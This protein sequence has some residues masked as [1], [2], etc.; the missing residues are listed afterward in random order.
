MSPPDLAD[1]SDHAIVAAARDGRN[2]AYRELLRRYQGPIHTLIY[3]VV[4]DREAAEEL[5]QDTF[6]KLLEG[7]PDY[8]G[9]GEFS[10]WIFKIAN[11]RALS[12]VRRTK[13][14]VFSIDDLADVPAPGRS[15]KTPGNSGRTPTTDDRRAIRRAVERA[16]TR[17][18]GLKRRCFTMHDLKGRSYDDI[19]EALGLDPG[20]VRRY[21][22]RAREQLKRTLGSAPE[23]PEA[24]RA[25]DPGVKRRVPKRRS[26]TG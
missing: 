16:A 7:L 19:A 24:R 20:E 6:V 12:H 26:R 25:P 11:N 21:V 13:P 14:H 8:R 10:T 2:D 23:I 5:T 1:A 9:E 18:T 15:G 3:K 4:K 17:L 22:H